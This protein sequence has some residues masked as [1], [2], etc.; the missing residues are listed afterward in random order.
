MDKNFIR[1][2]IF[3][4]LDLLLIFYRIFVLI[5]Y[6]NFASNTLQIL[7]YIVFIFMTLLYV[8]MII[9]NIPIRIGCIKNIK[10]NL[11][12]NDTVIR[13]IVVVF[14]IF[15]VTVLYFYFK[16]VHYY[17]VN[18]PFT[19]TDDF[20][21]HY[22]ERCELYNKNIYS[23][24]SNQYICTYDPTND[25]KYKIVRSGKSR[26]EVE[27]RITKKLEDDFL[28]C[29]SFTKEIKD[30]TIVNAFCREYTDSKK[31]Y[32]SRTNQP[33]RYNKISDKS[34]KNK[35]KYYVGINI[36]YIISIFE[37]FYVKIA[38][39][40]HYY[41]LPYYE[42]RCKKN[43]YNNNNTTSVNIDNNL[44]SIFGSNQKKN[45]FGF[46]KKEENVE[47]TKHNK[48]KEIDK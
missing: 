27:K 39:N 48:E 38:I 44:I 11:K 18:C 1:Y 37:I 43:S 19:L 40:I 23:R 32:C 36:I 25:F 12:D 9:I 24:Y 4:F 20:S 26:Y 14:Y 33:E 13:I 31:Y 29:V 28:V 8:F 16:Y 22:K 3:T 47:F 7:F 5:F 15:Q 46:E 42:F 21:Q 34:C 45:D 17:K 30:N 6:Q 41:D 35:T 2:A 10:E